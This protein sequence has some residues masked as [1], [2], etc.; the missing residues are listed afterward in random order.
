MFLVASNPEEIENI[1]SY[2]S[3]Q[4]HNVK[5]NRVQQIFAEGEI[6][7]DLQFQDKRLETQLQNNQ[8]IVEKAK[9]R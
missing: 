8:A 6:K 5:K 3:V 4:M 2:N 7:S 1:E 9:G